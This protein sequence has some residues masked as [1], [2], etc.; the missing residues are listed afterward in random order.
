MIFD[1]EE[2]DKKQLCTTE[3][4]SYPL[5]KIISILCAT[6]MVLVFAILQLRYQLQQEELR[7]GLIYLIALGGTLSGSH[8]LLT[9][10][11]HWESGGKPKA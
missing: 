5:A 10:I 9:G 4:T 11:R 8:M 1:L 2:H 3:W 6:G 7:D